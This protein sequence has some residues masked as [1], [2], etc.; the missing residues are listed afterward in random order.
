MK[1]RELVLHVALTLVVAVL[2]MAAWF[3]YHVLYGSLS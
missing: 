3:L 2:T 1:R